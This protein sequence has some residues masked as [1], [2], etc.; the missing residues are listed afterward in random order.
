LALLLIAGLVGILGNI[1]DTIA[2]VIC[3]G[4]ITFPMRPGVFGAA[5]TKR[6]SGLMLIMKIG[7]RSTGI[8]GF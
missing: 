2:D 3:R 5:L 1:R 8:I 6:F 4:E 7:S